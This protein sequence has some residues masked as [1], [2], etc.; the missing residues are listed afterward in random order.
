[1][2]LAPTDFETLYDNFVEWCQEEE[3]NNRPDKKIVKTALKKWQEKS[4]FGL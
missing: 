2:E 3:V 1:M 4:R